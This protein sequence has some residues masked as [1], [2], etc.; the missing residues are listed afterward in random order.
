MKPPGHTSHK[1]TAARLEQ[2]PKTDNGAEDLLQLSLENNQ[3]AQSM[4]KGLKHPKRTPTCIF[5]LAFGWPT[6]ET[7]TKHLLNKYRTR[8]ANGRPTQFLGPSRS[9]E[10]SSH[11][12]RTT[13]LSPPKLRRPDWAWK[14][15][16]PRSLQNWGPI[17]G[18]VISREF[19]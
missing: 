19:P 11:M 10:A 2:S 16:P 13:S 7:D 1:K 4:I 17:G 8:L 5:F 15:R 18:L 9:S 3:Y 14:A 6:M 12:S